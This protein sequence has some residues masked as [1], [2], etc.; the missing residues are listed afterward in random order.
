MLLAGITLCG[1]LYLHAIDNVEV[2]PQLSIRCLPAPDRRHVQRFAWPVAV[3]QEAVQELR[4]S[5][6]QVLRP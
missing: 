1:L 5:V 3:E 2:Q 4:F 6:R